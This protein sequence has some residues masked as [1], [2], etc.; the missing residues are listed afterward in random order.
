MIFKRRESS[1]QTAKE[2]AV[3]AIV[4]AL[5][6]LLLAWM[7]THFA[8]EK[9][10]ANE[11][12][13]TEY[14]FEESLEP[15]EELQEDGQVADESEASA[16]SDD[17]PAIPNPPEQVVED[18]PEELRVEEEEQ[19]VVVTPPDQRRQ[20]VDQPTTNEQIPE[21][22][23]YFLAEVDNSTLE[24]TIAESATREDQEQ[25]PV[26]ARQIESDSTTPVETPSPTR[27][28]QQTEADPSQTRD[29]P[30]ERDDQ[31]DRTVQGVPDAQPGEQERQE[32]RPRQDSQAPSQAG[33]TVAR[34]ETTPFERSADGQIRAPESAQ[35]A[36]EYAQATGLG[37]R[38][39]QEA[40]RLENGSGRDSVSR[41]G[42]A[43]AR[44]NLD[45]I[46]GETDAEA[47]ARGEQQRRRD[48]LFGDHAGDWQRT[49]Q[50]M[51]NYDVAV[52]TGSETQ[53]NTRRDEH[54]AFI[55]AFHRR[56]HDEWWQVLELLS[57][58]YGPSENISNRDLTVRL[59]IRVL[60]D[61][62]VDRVRIVNTS[63]NTFFDAEA[64]RVNY[65]VRRT[66]APPPNIL[67]GDGSVYLHWTFSRMPGRCGTHGASV[68]CP[69]M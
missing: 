7:V 32:A 24:Q 28:Q 14:V 1:N 56:I 54:A 4:A 20:S 33:S 5:L 26:D 27:D 12:F 16:A 65:D 59:E 30:N 51:E 42:V 22:D 52:T 69:A 48:S 39:R 64:I 34:E 37:A 13:I 23:E 29:R 6:L 46:F 18:V 43:R 10:P 2:L 36:A 63:G 60:S 31:N 11:E 40:S 58:R 8:P 3:A 50:A 47:R 45:Q 25:A 21:T 57:R 44:E 53:L 19:V 67:C 38:F 55:N 62:K 15:D 68:H 35:R 61:G 17:Q 49:R 9:S 41:D 66:A